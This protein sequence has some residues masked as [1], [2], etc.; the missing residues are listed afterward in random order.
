MIDRAVGAMPVY[1][2]GIRFDGT[3]ALSHD[4]ATPDADTEVWFA[5]DPA[6]KMTAFE[7]ADR[8]DVSWFADPVEWTEPKV[9]SAALPEEREGYD[10]LGLGAPPAMDDEPLPGEAPPAPPAL[11]VEE[12]VDELSEAELDELSDAVELAEQRVGELEALVASVILG[13]V[14]DD[15]FA[16]AA[17][18][19]GAPLP[20]AAAEQVSVRAGFGAVGEFLAAVAALGDSLPDDLSQRIDAITERLDALDDSVGKLM[21]DDVTDEELPGVPEGSSTFVDETL[22]DDEDL[23]NDDEDAGESDDDAEYDSQRDEDPDETPD[24]EDD[25][26]EDEPEGRYPRKKKKRMKAPPFKAKGR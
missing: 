17:V 12:Q 22:P 7:A 3:P 14:K 21:L 2:V 8:T 6:T 24:D 26:S 9:A 13:K 23:D 19:A 18:T 10:D 16:D 4:G 15:I 11:P 20:I 5:D 25:D 1:R